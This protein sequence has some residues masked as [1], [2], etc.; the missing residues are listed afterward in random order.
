MTAELQYVSQRY[1]KERVYIPPLLH[2]FS[3]YIH[4]AEE[5]YSKMSGHGESN[6]HIKQWQ[7]ALSVWD[8][9][10]WDVSH[11]AEWQLQP[12]LFFF[13]ASVLCLS[14]RGVADIVYP[15]FI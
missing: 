6:L 13:C 15:L 14:D 3:V 1:H 12:L 8:S 4:R 9:V 2:I 7:I 10:C 5:M 11:Q